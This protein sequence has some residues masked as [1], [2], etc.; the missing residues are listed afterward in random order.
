[1]LVAEVTSQKVTPKEGASQQSHPGKKETSS[2]GRGELFRHCLLK[3]RLHVRL[4]IPAQ[5]H[6]WRLGKYTVRD[7]LADTGCERRREQGL[8]GRRKGEAPMTWEGEHEQNHADRSRSPIIGDSRTAE[9]PPLNR[10]SFS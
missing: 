4:H 5:K 3:G 2:S 1:M 10:R 8:L 7:P 9:G 6:M